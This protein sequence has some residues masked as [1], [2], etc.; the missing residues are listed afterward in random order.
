MRV[1][2]AILPIV[3]LVL[4]IA[5]CAAALLP[6]RSA[7]QSAA[8]HDLAAVWARVQKAG[9]YHFRADVVQIKTPQA[10]M[11]N[12]GRAPSRSTLYLEGETD[13]NAHTLNLRLWSE[14]GAVGSSSSIRV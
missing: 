9:A 8:A 13:L 10:T 2:P 3:L 1:K 5:L 6:A 14:S 7:A 11:M 4:A 12:A